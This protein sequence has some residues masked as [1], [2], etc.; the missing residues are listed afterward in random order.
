[1]FQPI[2]YLHKACYSFLFQEQ[3]K[4]HTLTLKIS[5]I[6]IS[7]LVAVC[8]SFRFALYFVFHLPDHRAVKRSATMQAGPLGSKIFRRAEDLFEWLGEIEVRKITFLFLSRP[9]ET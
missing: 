8:S 7:A 4:A 1:M 2:S 5:V 3:K 9:T 6:C